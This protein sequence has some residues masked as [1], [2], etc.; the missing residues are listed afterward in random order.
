MRNI[1][2]FD[3]VIGIIVACGLAF[4]VWYWSHMHY[5]PFSFGRSY[6][7]KCYTP[8]A[9]RVDLQKYCENCGYNFYLTKE[10]VDK[11]KSDTL[12]TNK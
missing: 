10:E 5:N 8:T 1:Y 12:T 2:K 9:I 4:S 7:P 6:C 11:A 3:V